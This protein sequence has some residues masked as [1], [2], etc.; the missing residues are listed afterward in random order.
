[1]I[2]SITR[3]TGP[4]YVENLNKDKQNVHLKGRRSQQL[5]TEGIFIFRELT[6]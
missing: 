2:L 3:V 4:C 1:M 6:F 5:K